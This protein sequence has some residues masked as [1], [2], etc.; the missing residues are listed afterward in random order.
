SLGPERTSN[1]IKPEGQGHVDDAMLQRIE[2]ATAKKGR[3]DFGGER[4]H[5]LSHRNFDCSDFASADMRRVDFTG[6]SFVGADLTA[7]ELQGGNFVNAILDGAK[8]S[9]VSL[10]GSAFQDSSMRRAQVVGA[11]FDHAI[12][13]R[14]D[15][16]GTVFDYSSLRGV[17]CER[18]VFDGGSFKIADLLGAENDLCNFRGASFQGARLDGAYFHSSDLRFAS[19]VNSKVRGVEFAGGSLVGAAFSSAEVQA[20]EFKWVSLDFVEF[21]DAVLDG[22]SFAYSQLSTVLMRNASVWRTEV[23]SCDGYDVASVKTGRF[24]DAVAGRRRKEAHGGEVLMREILADID[25]FALPGSAKLRVTKMF[26]AAGIG[27]DERSDS[28][29]GVSEKAWKACIARSSNFEGKETFSSGILKAVK[30]LACTPLA[31]RRE[32]IAGL[33]EDWSA[34]MRLRRSLSVGFARQM[35]ELEGQN[36]GINSLLTGQ[37]VRELYRML[38]ASRAYIPETVPRSEVKILAS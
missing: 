33:I 12:V 23:G 26:A 21:D 2:Q 24:R 38:S 35:L 16:S 5:N 18:S 30:S 10:E 8:A 32:I 22:A 27:S 17:R 14:S 7:A 6:A 15:F 37:Q 1:W 19:F 31:S 11:K 20:S 34:R 25:S 3:H 36:C 28:K 9:F 29:R 13:L 4:T